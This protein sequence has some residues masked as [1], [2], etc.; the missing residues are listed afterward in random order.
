MP[1]QSGRQCS[2]YRAGDLACSHCPCA[3]WQC[4]FLLF[5]GRPHAAT[6]AC[7]GRSDLTPYTWLRMVPCGCVYPPL[8][9]PGKSI[10]PPSMNK[11]VPTT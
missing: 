11:V 1:L 4:S 3:I 6:P 8:A 7:F 9:K 2:R 10:M 5:A